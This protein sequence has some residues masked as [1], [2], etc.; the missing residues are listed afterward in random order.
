MVSAAASAAERYVLQGG[1][2]RKDGSDWAN[3]YTSLP[4]TLTRGDTYYVADGNYPGRTFSTPVSGTLPITIKKATAA[5]HGTSTG[6]TAAYGDGQ[7]SF[8]SGFQ[9]TTSNWV[10]DGQTGGGAANGWGQNFGFKITETSDSN[11]VIK[12]GQSGTANNI[13][14]KHV[15][16]QGKGSV[17]N[18]GGSMS[19]DGLAIY[20]SSDVTLSYFRMSGIGRC[21]FFISPKNAIIEHG[22]I[23]SFYGSGAVHS[24]V[25]SIWAFA[26]NIGDVTFRSNL[27]T[28][29]QSTGGIMWDNS[30]NTSARLFIY[31][32]VFYK[33]AGASWGQANGIIG[34]W[35]GGNG[36]QFR[37]V[38]VYNNTFINVNQESLST[39]PNV[40]SGNNAYNNLFYN[41]SSPNFAKFGGH[42]YNHFINSGGT[43]SEANGTSSTSGD[44][45][46]NYVGLD[47]R[48]KAATAAGMALTSPFKIDPLGRTRGL[49]GLA[50]RGAYEFDA[51]GTNSALAPPT[52]VKVQ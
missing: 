31:G 17:S 33:P 22:W 8:T 25:A 13:T 3:A 19:N 12:I 23:A 37:N 21:P 11:A 48:L 36:E 7:A 10:I 42:D 39:L 44:P 18:S 20:G 34:G 29:I 26:G 15:D 43:H 47:F 14:I 28:D 41:S 24:E 45:F 30:S 38:T 1:T 40:Y 27:F 46:V 16:L 35:T 32:N 5:D 49:D 52:N 50:D 2:G 6:W 9:F 4:S 51:G